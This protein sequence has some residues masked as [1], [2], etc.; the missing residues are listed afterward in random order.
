MTYSRFHFP[1]LPWQAGCPRSFVSDTRGI[2]DPMEIYSQKSETPCTC[3]HRD[4]RHQR[5]VFRRIWGPME[6]YSEGCET[7]WKYIQ[8]DL[9]PHGNIFRRRDPMKIYS[10]G[11]ETPWIYS[12]GCKT[13]WKYIQKDVRPLEN[14]FRRMWDPL[15]MYS[16]GCETPWKCIR[17]DIILLINLS[18]EV[19]DPA[20]CSWTHRIMSKFEA[21]Q[22]FLKG[23]FSILFACMKIHIFLFRRVSDLAEELLNTNS[24]VNS[25]PNSENFWVWIRGQ[26]RT[27]SVS[28]EGGWY[29]WCRLCKYWNFCV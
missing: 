6:M 1:R 10:E 4:L 15:E 13:P 18:S 26:I 24:S 23:I 29:C 25:K 28:D 2:W 17:I 19:S 14:V 21:C 20:V 16:E 12:E 3:N 8:K 9:R 22:D 27:I 11:S 7:P 5:N